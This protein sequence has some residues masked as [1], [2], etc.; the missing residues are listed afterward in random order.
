MRHLWQ[1][2][3]PEQYPSAG[4]DLS[5]K[6][7]AEW[8]TEKLPSEIKYIALG[9]IE[10]A[11]VQSGLDGVLNSL[12][13]TYSHK[14]NPSLFFFLMTH[15]HWNAWTRSENCTHLN[16]Q[17]IHGRHWHRPLNVCKLVSFLS[18]ALAFF[19][20]RVVALYA[21]LAALVCPLHYGGGNLWIPLSYSGWGGVFMAYRFTE[22]H[23]R[24]LSAS[25]C[26]CCCF[27]PC[28]FLKR[29]PTAFTVKVRPVITRTQAE[30]K[31]IEIHIKP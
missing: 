31:H 16:H 5:K 28:S 2:S 18:D 24:V 13:V 20:L 6:T 19:W 22:W 25:L 3:F 7:L 17:M 1:G 14:S 23:R 21:L 15:G 10:L 12:Y 29:P 27:N 26:C 30:K 8:M 4:G 11:V 9:N